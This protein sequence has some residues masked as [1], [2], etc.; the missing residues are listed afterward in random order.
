MRLNAALHQSRGDPMCGY[1]V[2]STVLIAV[3][4][5]FRA[6]GRRVGPRHSGLALGLPST[7][8]V[9]LI[10]CGW[11]HGDAVATRLAEAN[12]LGLVAAT[13][14]PLAYAQV[15]RL[16]SGLV[17]ALSAAVLGYVAVAGI[18]G[19]LP[20][21]DVV[22]RLGLATT[23]I[24]AASALGGR[25]ADPPPAGERFVPSRSRVLFFRM[26]IPTIYVLVVAFA[27]I[28]AGPSRA[29]LVS[30]FPSMSLVVLAV[31]HLE[32]GPSEASRIARVLPIGNLS[33]LAFLATF[34]WGCA[35]TGLRGGLIIGY[36]AAT[37]VLLVLEKGI[38]HVGV[39][40]ESALLLPR[41]RCAFRPS[42]IPWGFASSAAYPVTRLHVRARL[43]PKQSDRARRCLSHRGGFSPWVEPLGW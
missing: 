4:C 18:L 34:Y 38:S 29:G 17:P 26:V 5:G 2:K 23:T 42:G 39:S 32:A 8:A 3:I 12:L 22:S 15:V 14:L 11:E 20:A 7:T 21:M 13:A 6:L 28:V 27:Q 31:T 33:T 24:L 1:L 43:A 35:T 25:I 41:P 40:R 9:V 10:L 36:T 16:G 30:T 19:S 37:A